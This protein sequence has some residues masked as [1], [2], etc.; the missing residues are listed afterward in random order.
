[1]SDHVERA[2]LQTDLAAIRRKL[3]RLQQILEGLHELAELEVGEAE[4][5]DRVGVA[6]VEPEGVP[7]LDDGLPV[8]LLLEVLIAAFEMARLFRLRRPSTSGCENE[9]EEQENA[10]TT[11]RAPHRAAPF[12]SVGQV[13]GEDRVSDFRSC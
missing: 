5:L 9:A 7:V 1:S 11:P 12:R 3:P 6:R 4:L 13:L 2:E 10:P 8:L